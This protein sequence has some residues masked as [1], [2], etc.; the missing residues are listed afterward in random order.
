MY[1][2]KGKT[3]KEH[4]GINSVKLH[5]LQHQ[6]LLN[7]ILEQCQYATTSSSTS[8]CANLANTSYQN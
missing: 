7:Y 4:K 8:S 3:K 1:Y 5:L 6:N 2:Q